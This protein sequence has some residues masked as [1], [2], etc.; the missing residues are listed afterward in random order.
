MAISF[1]GRFCRSKTD[2]VYLCSEVN[3]LYIS[4]TKLINLG[5]TSVSS[6]HLRLSLCHALGGLRAPAAR[7]TLGVFHRFC[8]PLFTEKCRTYYLN[9]ARLNPKSV[10]RDFGEQSVMNYYPLLKKIYYFT[11]YN[12]YISC[13]F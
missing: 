11:H 1:L 5:E 7:Q 13:V 8:K 9:L 10:I 2:I 6:F 3:C 12:C 4:N